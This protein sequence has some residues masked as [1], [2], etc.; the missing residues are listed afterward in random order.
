MAC[1]Q[2]VEDSLISFDIQWEDNS[3]LMLLPEPKG[4]NVGE[5]VPVVGANV[6]K[7]QLWMNLLCL[8]GEMKQVVLVVVIL[9][10][11]SALHRVGWEHLQLPVF[12][13]LSCILVCTVFVYF[14][15]GSPLHTVAMGDLNDPWATTMLT[16]NF[17]TWCPCP[18]THAQCL[19]IIVTHS[20]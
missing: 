3:L 1:L 7:L 17:A 2:D 15:G 12:L 9:L 14:Q 10:S 4:L 20:Q 19:V 18:G 6:L 16:S 11:N 5:V 8:W 13:P